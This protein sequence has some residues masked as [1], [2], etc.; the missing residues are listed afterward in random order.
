MGEVPEHWQVVRLGRLIELVT[1][2]AFKS[3]GFTQRADDIRLL[4]GVNV[5]PGRVRWSDVVR[6][7]RSEHQ[8]FRAFEL[9]VGDIVLGMDRPIIQTGTRV[10]TIG[11]SDLPALLLQ[12]VA[13][14]RPTDELR[15]D[16][17]MLLLGGKSFADYLTPIFTGISVPHL[18]PE[19]IRSFC[20]LLPTVNEQ[21]EV[22]R[23]TAD[24][25][26]SIRASIVSVTREIQLLREYHTRLISDVVTGKRDVS[27]KAARLPQE[28]EGLEALDEIETDGEIDTE[29]AEDTDTRREEATT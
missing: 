7:P 15:G 11:E 3:D 4:R 20:F 21:R 27:E 12:R 23:W 29:S 28:V 18:S 8:S 9:K 10:A 19:Q 13:R 16:F 24:T 17:L 2:F 14:I 25:T 1:G 26:R 22:V 6:W 5:S